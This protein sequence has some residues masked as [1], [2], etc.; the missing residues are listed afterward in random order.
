MVWIHGGGNSVGHGGFYDGSNLA[1]T[2]DVVVL[3]VNYR[4][5]PFGYFRH[6]A[7]RGEGTTEAERSGNFATLDLIRALDWVR[8]N[9]AA[10]GGNPKNVT[11]FG[12]SAGG[13]NVVALLVSPLA[14]GRFQRAI[15][16]SAGPHASTVDEAEHFSDDASPGHRHS[17]GE[18]LLALLIRD[19]RATD[20][21]AAKAQVAAMPA[22]EVARYLRGKT[23][24]EVLAVAEPGNFAGILDI[25]TVIR[26]GT[27]VP[28][29][30][31]FDAVGQ[32]GRYNQ[33]P[34]MLGTTRDENKLFLFADPAYVRRWF[35]IFPRVRDPK[36]FE[37]NAE[38]TARMWKAAAADEPAMRLRR[39]KGQ[40]VWV[41]RFDWDEEPTILGT[42]LARYLGASHAFEIP[43]VF[44]HFELGKQVDQ[45]WTKENEPGRR[46]L[47]T[48]MM[49]YWAAFA[50]A[51]DPGRGRRGD[52]PQWSAWDGGVAGKPT[53]VVLDTPEGGGIRMTTDFVTK[54]S[55]VAQVEA[56]ARMPT[57]EDK[58][59]RLRELANFAGLFP[60][61][62]YAAACR[63]YPLDAYA[64]R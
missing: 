45:I 30:N 24:E 44:G 51:G 32:R 13:T 63:D 53:F 43:F 60:K 20:R 8:E 52:L 11:I 3:T 27:V 1:T 21:A 10:F 12:E 7:L 14:R 23:P 4:L 56:D 29:G 15:V 64:R 16:Q 9:I 34:I 35:G 33:V 48:A 22:H 28:L 5:G 19:G 42:D 26:D 31:P 2:E 61:E 49:S 54:A 18:L 17:S 50:Y 58:C 62:E 59:E 55:V 25:P 36:R 47:S 6:A 57:R 37:L 39:V 41:Y 46:A 38:Y 40:R